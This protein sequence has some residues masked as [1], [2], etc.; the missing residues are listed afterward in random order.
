[1]KN[2]RFLVK[3]GRFSAMEYTGVCCTGAQWIKG[4]LEC[5]G[6]YSWSHRESL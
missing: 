5:R 2:N 4:R 3:L 6:Q 1:M